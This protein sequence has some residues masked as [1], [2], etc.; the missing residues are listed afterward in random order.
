MLSFYSYS[1]QL[2]TFPILRSKQVKDFL[3]STD[4]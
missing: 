2:S 4:P 3:E 1:Q